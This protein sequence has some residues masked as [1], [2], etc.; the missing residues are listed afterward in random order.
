MT[1]SYT[2]IHGHWG[3]KASTSWFLTNDPSYRFTLFSITVILSRSLLAFSSGIE[4]SRD[5]LSER[6]TDQVR[7]QASKRG[8]DRPS[9]GPS[10]RSAEPAIERS[11]AFARTS[12]A[13]ERTT[14]WVT[15]NSSYRSRFVKLISALDPTFHDEPF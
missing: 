1:L 6:S 13:T 7:D 15:H 10:D 14:D 8:S 11:E 12:E 9:D 2:K 3:K 4:R 5:R